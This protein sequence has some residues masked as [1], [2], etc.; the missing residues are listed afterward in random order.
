MPVND[1]KKN[2]SSIYWGQHAGGGYQFAAINHYDQTVG[3]PSYKTPIATDTI[4][5]R[6]PD[7]GFQP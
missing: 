2:T 5:V 4:E 7:S 3:S 6:G 1:S